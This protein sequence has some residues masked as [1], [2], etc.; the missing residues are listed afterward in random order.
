MWALH[1]ILLLLVAKPHILSIKIRSS[2][3]R[4]DNVPLNFLE[5]CRMSVSQ[6]DENN[7]RST[8]WTVHP[9]W[10]LGG[11]SG[12]HMGNVRFLRSSL[13]RQRDMQVFVFPQKI[14]EIT[15]IIWR[16]EILYCKIRNNFI[17]ILISRYP[18][19]DARVEKII[20]VVLG[21]LFKANSMVNL[22]TFVYLIMKL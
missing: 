15:D 6:N 4:K 2:A 7:S 16:F 12:Q 11:I 14:V 21:Q 5:H 1:P 22:V 3:K 10:D 17:K 18:I 19:F 20:H 13:A 9:T 8:V